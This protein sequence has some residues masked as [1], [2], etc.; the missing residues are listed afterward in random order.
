MAA[1]SATR[2]YWKRIQLGGSAED[3]GGD[4]VLENLPTI[5]ADDA[6]KDIG[7]TAKQTRKIVDDASL[8]KQMDV[9]Y[10]Y[11]RP[12]DPEFQR[13]IYEKREF[14]FHKIPARDKLTS[15][16]DIKEYRDRHCAPQ[17]ALYSHQNFLG[18]FF[19]PDTP[20]KGILIFHGTGTGKTCAAI[21]IAEQFKPMVQKYN[22]KIYVLISGPVIREVWKEHLLKCTKETYVKYQDKTSLIDEAERLK[23]KKMGLNNAL[24]YYKFM[25]YRSFY[26]KVL[27]EKIVE[28][29]TITTATGEEQNVKTKYRKTEEGEYERDVAV[30]RI[31][32]LNNT[33]II[34]DE[35]HNLTGNDYGEA[36]LT[37]IRNSTNLRTVLLSATPMKNLADDI[38]ELLNFIRPQTS[39]IM[40]D[41]IFSSQTN[42]MMTLREGG[43]EYLKTKCRGYVSYLRG[44]DPVTFAKRVDMGTVPQGLKF[45]KMTP[46]TMLNFQRTW[47]N[48]AV[49][50]DGDSLDRKSEAVANFVF[51]GLSQDRRTITGY[52]GRDGIQ[53]IKNQLKT[54]ADVLNRKISEMMPLWIA[55]NKGASDELSEESDSGMDWLHI[56]D[57]GKTISGRIL[58]LPYLKYF[59]VKF[60]QAL[61]GIGKLVDGLKGAGTAFVYSNLVKVGIELFQEV[62][63]QNGY[64][65]YQEN[66]NNYVISS[67][68]VCHKCGKRYSLHKDIKDHNFYPATFITVTG[69]STEE[70][71]DYIP[72]DKQRIIRNV[73]N[74]LE[75][76]DGKFI[77]LV[78]GSKVMNEGVSLENIREIHILDVYFNF[79]RVDQVIG[80]GIRNCSH[81]KSITD[82]Y[83]YP[84][85]E[86]Y[87][88]AVTLVYEGKLST[89]EELY[90]K[91]ELKYLLIKRVERALKEVAIDCPLHRNGNIFPEELDEHKGCEERGDCP[92]ICDYM[93]CNFKCDDASL[94]AKWFD[95][96]VGRYG[97][98]EREKLDYS[99]FTNRLAR[100]EIEFAK[101]KI[102]DMYRLG[103]VYRLKEIVQYVK[104]G[105]SDD[106]H[107][108]LFD[109]MFVYR[110]MQEL[111]PKTENDFNNFHDTIIDSYGN[112]GYLIHR[113]EYYIFQPFNQNE[114]VP[115]YYRNNYYQEML[116]RLSLYNYMKNTIDWQRY[117][118]KKTSEQD[119]N[120]EDMEK[121]IFK[122]TVGYDFESVR[123]YYDVRAENEVVGVIDKEVSRRKTKRPDEIKDVFKIRGKREK[124]LDKKR[125]TGIPSM[126]GAVCTTSK[127]KEYLEQVATDLGVKVKLG[128][129]N[130]SRQELC[131]QIR[132]KLLEREKYDT[133]GKTYIIVPANHPEFP[134]PYNLRDRAKD[135][136]DKV[137]KRVK[138]ATVDVKKVEEKM[139][140]SKITKSYTVI[141]KA[142]ASSQAILEEL[143]G[144][145]EKGTWTF[146]LQ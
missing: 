79:G 20:Y 43:L 73:F 41:K 97:K 29:K 82:S 3:V 53:T 125:G 121:N 25:S 12:E 126:K 102:K 143:G 23:Q 10:T 49:K 67:N 111:L 7:S 75:N 11:P 78:L 87:K 34:A 89:E 77:K 101:T 84:F 16:Q 90:R 130:V 129:P 70:M 123:E 124:I 83:R 118:S 51:P 80:R 85:V 144:K 17:F 135:L 21:S 60:A 44:A 71:Q 22:M 26:K 15:Y 52:Y 38:V 59:S 98:I 32:H 106:Q 86:V 58:R 81:H 103:P 116:N 35:A 107:R 57:S 110:A 138:G 65:E 2:A 108:E 117:K 5:A 109:E 48:D 74:T 45:T 139:G 56:S 133:E 46:C 8:L 18:N 28:R 76:K 113:G 100:D 72:E 93:E 122:E 4:D 92:A 91:A 137:K 30:D 142:P 54:S 128:D 66:M 24:Q 13:K 136:V 9:E 112:Q 146:V 47:Y 62:L 134:F 1:H 63:L 140:R 127:S 31:Y 37:V 55:E 88:Y 27:G 95:K 120:A 68:T 99:T 96:K 131:D 40:R 19:N 119:G 105:Y 132:D 141:V 33:V 69:K 50:G 42:H 94:N 115:M 6:D 104:K 145:G 64:L 61:E 36:L 114:D 14:Y 39:P